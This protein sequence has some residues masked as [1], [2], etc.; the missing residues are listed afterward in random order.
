VRIEIGAK[1]DRAA[2]RH[3]KT[4]IAQ[5]QKTMQREHHKIYEKTDSTKT[6]S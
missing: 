4:Q 3:I 6:E 1:T 5:P 2:R